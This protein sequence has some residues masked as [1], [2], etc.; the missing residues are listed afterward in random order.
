MAR[1]PTRTFYPE[2]RLAFGHFI[3]VFQHPLDWYCGIARCDRRYLISTFGRLK[4][5]YTGAITRGHVYEGQ[6]WAAV[7][8]AGLIPLDTAARLVKNAIYLPPYLAQARQ[9][10]VTGHT[11]AELAALGVADSTAWNYF[12]RAAETVSTA[13]LLRL[14][15]KLVPGD[16][17]KALQQIKDER[18]G[19]PLKELFRALQ[20][21][22][23]H[24]DEASMSQL[25]LARLALVSRKVRPP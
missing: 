8:H 24:L 19:G 5:P 3:G 25:R 4:S 10:F 21:K 14:V 16:L 6:R 17:W 12:C 1:R 9:A 23:P 2:R 22:V 11:P 15:P 20:T 13:E 18:L 7:K